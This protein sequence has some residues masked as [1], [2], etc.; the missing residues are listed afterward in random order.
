MIDIES[1]QFTNVKNAVV[2]KYPSCTCSTLDNSSSAPSFPYLEFVQKDNPI[3]A[4]SIDS[5]SK[6]NHVQPMIQIDVFTND[7]MLKAKQ[8]MATT[9]NQM[10]ADGWQRIFGPQPMSLISPYRLTCRYQAIVKQNAPNDF[11]VI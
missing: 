10:Q 1:A 11:S 7:T 2:S 9:D 6:E 4:Q 3:Y 5:G 8:I